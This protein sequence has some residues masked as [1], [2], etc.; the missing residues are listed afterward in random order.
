MPL[1]QSI[2]EP[3]ALNMLELVF[4]AVAWRFV[5]RAHPTRAYFASWVA[6]VLSIKTS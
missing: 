1:A 4:L 5:I 3:T 6:K 2:P